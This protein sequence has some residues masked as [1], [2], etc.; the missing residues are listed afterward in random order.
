MVVFPPLDVDPEPC[1]RHCRHERFG[2]LAVVCFGIP[3]V[4]AAEAY[5]TPAA[6]ASEANHQCFR[7]QNN[8]K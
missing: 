4:A 6:A 2:V 5:G 1:H 7:F 8:N 3:A